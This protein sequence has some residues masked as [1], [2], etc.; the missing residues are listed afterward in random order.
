[1]AD[2]FALEARVTRLRAFLYR[3]L[4]SVASADR[5]VEDVLASAEVQSGGKELDVAL[6][7]ALI[8]KAAEQQASV[9]VEECHGPELARVLGLL[10]RL[11][12]AQ[13][14][15]ILMHKY[16]RFGTR[17]IADVLGMSEAS[18]R[19]VLLRG[20]SALGSFQ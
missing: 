7:R 11:P 13:R 14:A 19:Q 18:T 2:A 3:L 10:Y 5:I 20:Y 16:E 4:G 15:A 17:Q 6:F 8:S 1:M 9:T 12:L